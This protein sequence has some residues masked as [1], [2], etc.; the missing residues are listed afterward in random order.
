MEVVVETAV[1]VGVAVAVDSRN[2]CSKLNHREN[3]MDMQHPS[4][5]PDANGSERTLKESIQA[6]AAMIG[7]LQRRERALEDLV[8]EQLQLLQSAI[9]NADQ[10]VNRVVESALPRLTQLSN[11]ALTQT[12]E[13]A[14]ERFNKTMATAEQTVQ[15]ATQRYAHAQHSL[16]TTTTRRMWIASIALLVAGVISL[17]VA[18]YALY[19]TK[20]AIAEAAQLRAEITFLDRVARANLVACGKD[21]LCAEIDKKGPRYGDKGQYREVS[22]RR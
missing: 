16:E 21:R 15:Q 12:L 5:L 4:A 18:G 3:T 2:T 13:P 22:V 10:R 14:T 20:A 7:T 17:V 6:L 9:N 11:Q 8:R 19:S 1:E